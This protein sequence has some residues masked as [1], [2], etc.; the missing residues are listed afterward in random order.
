MGVPAG[1]VPRVRSQSGARAS[2]ATTPVR[3]MSPLLVTVMVKLA[4]SPLC[5]TWLSG[6]F[7]TSRVGLITSTKAVLVSVT[8][9]PTS[10]VPVMTTVLVK[11]AVR[12]LAEQVY[13]RNP[14]ETVR[15]PTLVSQSGTSTSVTVTGCR[16]TSPVLVRLMVK[17]TASPYCTYWLSGDLVMAM[18]GTTTLTNASAVP[19]TT[20]PAA[21]VP[22][23]TTVLVKSA[24]T[25]STEQV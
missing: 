20:R 24:V 17:V 14:P 1:S 12:L 2:P 22:V 6:V 21:G 9:S 10:G 18:S 13:S 19:V 15:I 25:L 7:D 23:A 5:T 11:S 4:V 16:A 8:I 3:V